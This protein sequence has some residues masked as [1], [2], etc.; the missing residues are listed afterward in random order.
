MVEDIP[1]T[2]F[3]IYYKHYEF[4]V[5]SFSLTNAPTTFIS[6]MNGVFK[7]FVDSVIIVFI[8]YILIY[9]KNKE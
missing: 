7:S 9:S 1:N 3:Q 6:T 4:L 8:D 5:M 2:T